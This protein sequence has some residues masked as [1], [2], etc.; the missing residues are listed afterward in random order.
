MQRITARASGST[1][2]SGGSAAPPICGP[3]PFVEH[4]GT[5]GGF[6]NAMRIYPTTGLAITAMTNTT[7]AWDLHSLFNQLRSLP[8]N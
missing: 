1:T 6:W 8:W 3:P 7:S 4:Y 5:G 2:A